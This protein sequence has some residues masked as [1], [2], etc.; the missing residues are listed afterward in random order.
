MRSGFLIVAMLAAAAGSA[1]GASQDPAADPRTAVYEVR[2]TFDGHLGSLSNAPD[3]PVRR[4]GRV[5][6]T[7]Q[8]A[9]LEV[10]PFGDDVVYHGVLQLDVDIDLCEGTGEGSSARLCA[11]SV[12]GG[13]PVN[14]ELS[15][16]FDDR[17]GYVTATQAKGPFAAKAGGTCGQ[18]AI[19]AE[20]DAFPDDSMANIF[21]GIDLPLP[22]GPLRVGRYAEENVAMEVVRV[23][24]RGARP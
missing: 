8:V 18:E 16:Y 4:N 10:V 6:M 23:V 12:A 9:G 1:P 20:R 14:V 19:D 2:F 17:G 11:I 5:V 24:R 15:V 22:S 21:N 13:G 7:G 3:C